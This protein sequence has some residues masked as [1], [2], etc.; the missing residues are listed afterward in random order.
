MQ[1]TAGHGRAWHGIVPWRGGRLRDS[2]SA[3]GRDCA[4]RAEWCRR[5]AARGAAFDAM[6]CSLEAHHPADTLRT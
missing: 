2:A 3:D 6:F 4:E 1:R 5:C